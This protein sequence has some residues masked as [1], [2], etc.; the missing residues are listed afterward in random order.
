MDALEM[1]LRSR[2]LAPTAPD[3]LQCP[4]FVEGDLL[5]LTQNTG[6]HI[7]FAGGRNNFDARLIEMDAA[8]S[9]GADGDATMADASA[10]GAKPTRATLL[11]CVPDIRKEPVVVLV[12]M[13]DPTDVVVRH[14]DWK[15]H[16]EEEEK[17]KLAEAERA[18]AKKAAE[19]GK[20]DGGLKKAAGA[21]LA[22]GEA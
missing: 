17:E 14:L 10:G 4:S 3:T 9:E 12:N 13:A 5:A 18:A 22:F 21:E 6:P 20:A 11:L 1:C 15:P 19:A 7:F 16:D 8:A 2:H